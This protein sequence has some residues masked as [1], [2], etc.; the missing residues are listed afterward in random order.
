[1]SF[2]GQAREDAR[3]TAGIK[4]EGYTERNSGGIKLGDWEIENGSNGSTV[5]NLIDGAYNT[6]PTTI[7]TPIYSSDIPNRSVG[8][9]SVNFDGGDAF[10][11][12]IDRTNS[13]F[14][15]GQDKSFAIGHW[16]KM[17]ITTGAQRSISNGHW[18]FTGGYMI[19][20]INGRIYAGLGSGT[21]GGSVYAG[22]TGQYNDN[23]W[24][25]MLAIFNQKDK[26]ITIYVDGKI[27][28]IGDKFTGSCGV[29]TSSGSLDY[30]SCTSATAT[31]NSNYYLCLGG[32]STTCNMERFVGNLD[33]VVI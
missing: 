22:T 9:F 29:Y 11:L 14:N 25:Y 5:S 13:R 12:E 3:I 17:N 4:F 6:S 23:K 10:A 26:K 31:A 20:I 1:M 33:N 30:S 32:G 19:Q 18:G 15:F 7:G 2:T 28:P 24:H 21:V 27:S 16:F 8:D